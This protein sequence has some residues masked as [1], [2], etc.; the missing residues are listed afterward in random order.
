MENNNHL[1]ETQRGFIK[2]YSTIDNIFVLLALLEYCKSKKSKLHFALLILLQRLIMF[3]E[4]GYGQ[5]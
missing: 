5:N 3:V 1:S 4:W 2:E